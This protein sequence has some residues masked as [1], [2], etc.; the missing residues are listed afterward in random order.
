MS[1][2]RSAGTSLIE[3]V[4]FILVIGL[5]I[6]GV[7]ILFNQLTQASVD[8]MVRKQTLALAASVLEE[9][10]LR[11]FTYCDPDSANVY[12]ATAADDTACG[13]GLHENTMGPEGG[14]TRYSAA[15]RF[16]NV[17]DYHNFEMGSGTSSPGIKAV[18]SDGTVAI[19]ALADYAVRVTVAVYGGTDLPAVAIDPN[20]VLLITVTAQHVP[21]GTTVRLQ[22]YRLRYA[23]N[24]P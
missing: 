5:S 17:S 15:T 18:D 10:E 6:A 22:G 24:S 1:A 19:A 7:L 4:V 8:P 21:S 23:P 11:P 16:D 3:L 2:S 13:A 20:G 9:I 12:T 14:E